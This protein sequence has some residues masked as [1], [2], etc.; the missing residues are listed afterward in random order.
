MGEIKKSLLQIYI[1]FLNYPTNLKLIFYNK[2]N[3]IKK[4]SSKN[5]LEQTYK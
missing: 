2:R 3:K 5:R 1:N 4:I